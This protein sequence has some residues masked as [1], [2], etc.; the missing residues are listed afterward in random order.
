MVP[1]GG[2]VPM[3]G[4]FNSMLE[5][6][7]LLKCSGEAS[8]AGDLGQRMRLVW[9]QACLADQHGGAYVG[10][11]VSRSIERRGEEGVHAH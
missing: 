8:N 5:V 4:H 1:V 3:V 9:K 2:I 11:R 6:A 7:Q 10:S